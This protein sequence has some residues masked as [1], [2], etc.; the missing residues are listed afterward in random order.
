MKIGRRRP[1]VAFL[2]LLLG[3]TVGQAQQTLY[4]VKMNDGFLQRKQVYT[5]NQGDSLQFDNLRFYILRKDGT[6]E[7]GN[8]AQVDTF[9]FQNPGPGLYRP[10]YLRNND[11]NN[12]NS[13]YSLNRSMQSDHFVVFWEK[14]FGND[15]TKANARYAFS[16]A[17]LLQ[18]AEKIWEVNTHRLGFADPDSSPTLDTYKICMFVHYE[19]A[20][21]ATGSGVDNKA[22]TLDVNPDAAKTEVTTAH[23]IG[24]TFQYI[25]GCD[26]GTTHGWRYG[27]GPNGSGGCA[28]WES[29]AQWQ[30]YKVY[31]EKQFADGW[32]NYIYRT[33]HFNLLHEQIRYYNFYVQDYW[34]QLHGQ[35]FIGRLWRE[36]VYPED[37][38]EAYQRITGTSQEA[39]CDEMFDYARRAVTWD[40]DGIRERGRGLQD[41]YIMRMNSVDDGWL[42]IDSTLCV[43]NYGYNVIRLNLSEEGRE[44]KA[45]F[46]GIAGAK[47]FRA[48]QVDK[49][50]WRYGFVALLS[51][52]SRVYG[53]MHAET[54]SAVTFTVPDNAI[55][56]WFVVSGAP[57]EH[58]RHPWDMTTDAAGNDANT[59]QSLA[60]D[61]QWPY[62]VR[63]TGTSWVG[64]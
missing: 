56:L 18:R 37:P 20:W 64:R 4:G 61:E 29:C 55:R 25:V 14:G 44:V 12:D 35:D 22:G 41:L 10:N 45:E 47:G 36:S 38:V 42:Q 58:W 1:C 6:V 59:P 30:A 3:L 26:H 9:Y 11:F 19:T 13:Q 27:F 23:E 16:P 31:P 63:F 48:Y 50:G 15:P 34:C 8:Y 60:N 43:Q 39:F 7:R 57:K 54:E 62:Q 2:T 46:K 51:D 52:N 49:A 21:R 5:I 53:E 40:I 28:W 33:A 17:D 32:S 24:H